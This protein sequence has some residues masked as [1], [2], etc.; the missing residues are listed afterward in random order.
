MRNYIENIL[1]SEPLIFLKGAI[2]FLIGPID[3]KFAYLGIVMAVDMFLGI[4]VAIK[5]KQFKWSV[6]FKKLRDKIIIYF[7]WIA[8]FHAFDKIAGMTDSARLA[9][10]TVLAILEILSAIK[11]TAQL[12]YKTIARALEQAYLSLINIVPIS[13]EEQ[14]DGSGRMD[15][16]QGGS[17]KVEKR[18]SAKS[19]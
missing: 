7:I 13:T 2:I 15:N 19:D 8:M 6:L 5:Q 14:E 4:Q 18:K 3:L 16:R 12:G 17:G 1:N 9:V 10:V 11:N